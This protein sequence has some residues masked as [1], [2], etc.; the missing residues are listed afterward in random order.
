MPESIDEHQR[1]RALDAYRVLDSL[2]E[3]AYD[4]IVRLAA[5]IC[6]TPIALVSLID[7]DRQWLKAKL[8]MDLEQ[9]SRNVAFCDH[10]I[11]TPSQLMEVGDATGDARFRDN[12]FVAGEDG[13]RFYAGM[14]LVTPEG[15]AIGT[16]CVLDRAPRQLAAGQQA[17]LASLARLTMT[18]LENR[19]REQEHQRDAVLASVAPVPVAGPGEGACTV[20]VL[21]L[22]DYA[23]AV[24]RKGER[25]VE[26]E[27]QQLEER[28]E[29]SLDA[30]AGDRI[31]RVTGSVELIVVLH[32]DDTAPALARLA[33][34]VAGF[35]RGTGLRVLSGHAAAV[36]GERLAD[37][38]LRADEALSAAKDRVR[39][40]D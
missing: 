15:A 4:D 7:R 30:R 27:L 37:T 16:V 33:A 20:L 34:E 8:G 17:A 5:E 28:L 26:R 10:A 39:E 1:Q 2:P 36:P 21:E 14:P 35:E 40:V 22:Q 3:T 13:I 24:A 12:P 19:Q 29:A 23:G 9:T 6:D 32:G 25:A 11:R 18:L 38:F 31:T